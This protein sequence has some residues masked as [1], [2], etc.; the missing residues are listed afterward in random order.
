MNCYGI[1][2]TVSPNIQLPFV[3][4]PVNHYRA[5]H[6]IRGDT[7][8][9]LRSRTS[10]KGNSKRE[11]STAPSCF[12]R[13]LVVWTIT[14]PSMAYRRRQTMWQTN[15]GTKTETHAGCADGVIS[16]IPNQ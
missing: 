11:S 6:L 13:N 8:S 1:A 9:N 4:A 15:G 3:N 7:S 14:V 10:P 2:V 12:H 16:Q 5:G